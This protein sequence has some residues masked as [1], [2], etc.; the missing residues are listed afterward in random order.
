MRIKYNFDDSLF[1]INGNV[2][3]ADFYAVRLFVQKI[4][5]KRKVKEHVASG[6][7]NAAGLMD[8]I[9]HYLF[10][11]YELQINPGVFKK[12]L[13]H[14]NSKLGDE[15]IRK[16]LFDFI[17]V[18]PPIEVYKGKSSASY[19]LNS[20]SADRSNAE[21]TLEELILLHIANYNP[22]NKKLIELFDQ[23]YFSEKNF[24]KKQLMNSIYFFKTKKN[25]VRI[26]KM[27]LL[28]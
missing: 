19:Y 27:F 28:F 4:N 5:S 21:V 26:I 22:A 23:N 17:S 15:K 11:L 20:F 16:V 12:A 18:F 8:E 1:E 9:Y 24:I 13:N 3:L 2:I 25:L 10:R 6:Q 7:V 14:L